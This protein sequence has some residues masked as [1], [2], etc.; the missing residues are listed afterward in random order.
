MEVQVHPWGGA[1]APTP[2]PHVHS[3]RQRG[4]PKRASVG[5]PPS[6]NPEVSPGTGPQSHRSGFSPNFTGYT[7]VNESLDFSGTQYLHLQSGVKLV[8]PSRR[9]RTDPAPSAQCERHQAWPAP[10][11]PAS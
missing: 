11:G 2:P 8:P 3:E 6:S 10:P 4:A 7:A 1:V 9:Q 5:G